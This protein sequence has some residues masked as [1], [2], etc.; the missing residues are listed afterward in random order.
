MVPSRS[1]ALKV[2][3]TSTVPL[4]AFGVKVVSP[5]EITLVESDLSTRVPFAEYSLPARRFS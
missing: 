4:D 2:N 3:L 1:L 5:V